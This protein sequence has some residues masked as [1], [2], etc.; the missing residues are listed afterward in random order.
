MLLVERGV[1]NLGSRVETVQVD[2]RESID[3]A[4]WNLQGL[5][6]KRVY[7]RNEVDEHLDCMAAM[8]ENIHQFHA[9][10]DGGSVAAATAFLG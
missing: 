3:L 10:D 1:V 8:L 4:F 2:A 7:D 6:Q 5:I 9:T